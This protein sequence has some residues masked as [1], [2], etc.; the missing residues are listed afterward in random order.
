MVTRLKVKITK[1]DTVIVIEEL[2]LVP[3]PP[4]AELV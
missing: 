3:G 1:D 2:E 4:K